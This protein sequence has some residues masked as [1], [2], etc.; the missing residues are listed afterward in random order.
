MTIKT[1]EQNRSRMPGV[2]EAISKLIPESVVLNNM[3]LTATDLHLLGTAFKKNEAAETILS[4]FVIGLSSS[5]L[6]SGVKLV[7]ATKNSD[8]GTEAFNFEII[9]KIK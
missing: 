5:D 8:Y 3:S 1:F 7:Q 6:F 4:R 2:F 9:G